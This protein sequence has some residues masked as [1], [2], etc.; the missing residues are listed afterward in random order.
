[1]DTNKIVAMNLENANLVAKGIYNN[2]QCPKCDNRT[3]EAFFTKHTKE[4]KYDIWFECKNCGN[5]WLIQ[6]YK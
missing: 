4:G 6:K 2:L 3:A 5:V 1:M